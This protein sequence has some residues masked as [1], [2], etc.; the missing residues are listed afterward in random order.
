MNSFAFKNAPTQNSVQ[1]HTPVKD[2]AAFKKRQHKLK[3][4]KLIKNIFDA[5][6]FLSIAGFTFSTLFWGA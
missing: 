4:Q 1:E 2:L 3:R 5:A 6:I